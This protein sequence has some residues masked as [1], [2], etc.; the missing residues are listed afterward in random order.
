MPRLGILAPTSKFLQRA[1]LRKEALEQLEKQDLSE[2]VFIVDPKLQSTTGLT[3]PT[4]K[5]G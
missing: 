3:V 2:L 4:K 5:E 1:A